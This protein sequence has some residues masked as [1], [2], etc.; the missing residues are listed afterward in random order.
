MVTEDVRSTESAPLG[1][2]LLL[3]LV[4]SLTT[5]VFWN[6]IAFIAKHGYAF[7]VRR[8]ALLYLIMGAIYTVGAWKAASLLR[9]VAHICPVRRALAAVIAA[10]S[11]LSVLPWCV[12][13]EASFWVSALGVSVSSSLL[14]PIV[15]SYLSAGRH[16]QAM[17]RAIGAFNLVWMSAVVLPMFAVAPLLEK[18]PTLILALLGVVNTTALAALRWFPP[19]PGS[20]HAQTALP[21]VG[22]DYPQLLRT[23]RLL[24]PLSYLL[25]S[26][27]API[28]P[29]R[30]AELGARADRETMLTSTWM[31]TRVLVMIGMLLLAFWHGKWSVLLV[32]GAL[33]A[34][35][36]GTVIL[37]PDMLVM[38]GGF[39][40]L[41]A[42]LAIIYYA[43]LYYGLAVGHAEVDAGGTHEALIGLGY[44]LGP[45]LTLISYAME[46]N[47][48]PERLVVVV[49]GV[50]TLAV[51]ARCGALFVAA[52]RKG[53]RLHEQG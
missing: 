4:A 49:S 46:M 24:L 16:G 40:A 51:A 17:R 1:A 50:A 42:G 22:P 21:H 25:T 6:A 36:F 26:A 31:A 41:G 9:L 10:I 3:T 53:G 18:Q 33:L 5:S 15:E 38:T 39:I 35:G 19:V 14:W 27:M 48:R 37:A 12:P 11:V 23:A 13:G 30:L 52:K 45:A 8:S 44:T 47:V 28:L 20:H 34:G 29:F 43:A 7:D 32:G 2:V